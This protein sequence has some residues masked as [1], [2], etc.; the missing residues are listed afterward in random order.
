MAREAVGLAGW[1]LEAPV[2]GRGAQIRDSGLPCGARSQVSADVREQGA[3]TDAVLVARSGRARGRG[4]LPSAPD[5]DADVEI[6]VG[7]RHPLELDPVLVQLVAEK[8]LVRK[9]RVGEVPGVRVDL[10]LIA[11][12]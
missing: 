11:H 3:R 5:L 4:K 7:G 1:I 6:G 10:V 12:A 9:R 2:L 8:H